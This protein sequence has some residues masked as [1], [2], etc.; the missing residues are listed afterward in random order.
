MSKYLELGESLI[1][2]DPL[3]DDVVEQLDRLYDLI[4]PE[5]LTEFLYFYEA[6]HLRVNLDTGDE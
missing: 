2:Q 6:I 3:P 5:E 1:K 4:D